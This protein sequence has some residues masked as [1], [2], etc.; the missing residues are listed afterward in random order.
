MHSCDLIILIW[1][2][3]KVY[4]GEC[5]GNC[6]VVLTAKNMIDSVN[7]CLKKRGLAVGQAKRMVQDRNEW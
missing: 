4:N 6:P 7:K 3:Q 2:A 1:I 5:M